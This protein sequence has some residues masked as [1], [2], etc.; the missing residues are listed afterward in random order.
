MVVAIGLV[1]VIVASIALSVALLGSTGPSRRVQ[2][3]PSASPTSSHPITT[4]NAAPPVWRVGWGSAMAW[5]NGE[6]S[7]VTVR[8]LATVGTGGEA[9]RI[10]IS[11]VFGNEPL[12]IGAGSVGLAAAGAGVVPGTLH[13][14]TFG[15][16]R[17][18][19]VPVGQVSYSDAVSMDVSDLQTLAISVYVSGRELVTVHPCCTKIVSYFTP[20]G[21]G[22][23]TGSVSGVGLSEPSP[24]E[25]WVDAVDVLQTTGEGSIVVVGDSI[26]D[27][28]HTSVRWTDVLQKRIDMLPPSEQRAV[29]N[30]G[31]T[32]N[33]LT[34]VVRTDDLT[35]GGP[36]GVSR[37]ARDALTQAGVS[38]VVLF[39]GTNDLWFGATA[40]QVIAGYEQAIAAAHGAG[41]RI[42]V[43]TLLPR[44]TSPEERWTPLQQRYLQQ[45]DQWIL[46]SGAFDAVL[47]L[48]TSVADVYDGG[49]AP[50]AI[51]PMYDSGDHLH[52][53]AQ[54]QTAMAN[55]VD[56]A[57]LDVPPLP[58][59]PPLV[60][61]APTPGCQGVSGIPSAITPTSR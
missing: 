54:G 40:D 50:T 11:N 14:L 9:V 2:D 39:L 13:A 23:L 8:D 6:A 51:F 24:W 55:A 25:R 38:E 43:V 41:V 49:C 21:G 35:G 3:Q 56:G 32:A 57:A 30:E 19:T 17:G 1:V 60:T 45:V 5:G 58:G 26:T 22:D 53:D 27:G 28:Y 46:T 34:A 42:D 29:V 48:G 15:G 18:T 4:T 33:A 20:N 59:V 47:N 37:L 52:P 44:S 7:N 61:V 12:V 10:R 16:A 31:I 36:S